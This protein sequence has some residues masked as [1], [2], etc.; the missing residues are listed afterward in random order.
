MA[1]NMEAIESIIINGVQWLRLAVETTGAFVIALGISIAVYHFARTFS[2]QKPE[3]YDA[4]RQILARYLALALEL[5]LSADILSTAI[6]P[7]WEQIG[8]LGAIATIRTGLNYFLMRE[9]KKETKDK[10]ELG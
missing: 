3:N 5:Q 2:L 9:I 10:L 6:T 7:S 4:V 8:K 1:G